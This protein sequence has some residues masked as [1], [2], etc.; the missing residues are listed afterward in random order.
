MLMPADIVNLRHIVHPATSTHHTVSVPPPTAPTS[1]PFTKHLI[2]SQNTLS[3]H[4]TPY[5]FTK[6]L[7]HSQN[8]LSIH[9]TPYPF[10]KHL[11][12]SQNTFSIHKTPSPFTK[13]LLHSQKT[14]FIHK[15]TSP[16][17]KPN[18]TNSEHSPH[19]L[20]RLIATLFLCIY[21]NSQT[22]LLLSD[23]SLFKNWFLSITI[24]LI[25]AIRYCAIIYNLQKPERLQTRHD[26]N[27]FQIM[28]T[29]VAEFPAKFPSVIKCTSYIE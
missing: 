21:Y 7:I 13:H 18:A 16:F 5:P 9:K 8:T 26:S 28:L 12:H 22:L 29:F 14:F 20:P 3:I 11:L 17:T 1:Y 19:S 10:T 4:K 25:L 23:I 2:H 27:A 24:W 15:T 6:H